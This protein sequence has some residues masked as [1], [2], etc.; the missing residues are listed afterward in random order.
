MAIRSES[1]PRRSR[2]SPPSSLANSVAHPSMILAAHEGDC[3]RGA[4]CVDSWAR[5][6]LTAA[7]ARGP[8]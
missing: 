8:D 6:R 2:T 7:N 3:Q 5:G 4:K 1:T